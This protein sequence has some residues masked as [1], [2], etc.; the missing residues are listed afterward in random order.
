MRS[1]MKAFA[2]SIFILLSGCTA[3]GD[4]RE[5]ET[6][7][8]DE[9]SLAI[10]RAVLQNWLDRNERGNSIYVSKKT[11]SLPEMELK[12]LEDCANS[13]E[14][15]TSSL[16]FAPR[17]KVVG[18]ISNPRLH[19]INSRFWLTSDPK[20]INGM[21]EEGR[22]VGLISLSSIAFDQT[23]TVAALNFSMVCGSLCGYGETLVF[24][25]TATGWVQRPAT[26]E[27]WIS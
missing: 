3:H 5:S 15:K 6:K 22:P 8:Q 23:K 9:D 26:C 12:K 25:R 18:A 4:L 19:F 11:H 13:Q 7:S 10:F 14:A 20:M 2:L 21:I 27:A 16:A 24:D 17:S 1:T